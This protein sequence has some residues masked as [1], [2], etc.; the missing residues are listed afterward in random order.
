MKRKKLILGV[1]GFGC[2][3]RGLYEVLQHAP[4]TNAEIK[5]ICIK[6][7]GKQR[8]ADTTLFTDDKNIILHD[9]SINVVVELTDDADAAFEI[10]KKAMENGKAVV[11]ANKKMI[12]EHLYELY[13]LQQLYKVPFLYE[14]A[15]CAGIPIIRSLEEYYDNDLLFSLEGIMNGSTNYILSKI[16]DEQ[17]SFEHAL[18]EAQQAGFAET[19]PTLDIEAYDPKYKLCILLLHAFGI[20]VKQEHIFH[21]GIQ[22]L[23]DFDIAYARQR[24]CRIKLVAQCKK[25]GNHVY[26][27]VVPQFVELNSALT[28]VH[29]EFNGLILESAF[30]EYQFFSGRGAGSTAT[31]SAVLSDISALGYE[32]KYEYKKIGTAGSLEHN[33]NIDVKIYLR[34]SNEND[35]NEADFSSIEERYESG[36]TRYIAGSMK[37]EAI[38][39]AKW[40]KNENVSLISMQN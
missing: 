37:L 8:S 15:V 34:Y 40:L 21:F 39:A 16:F 28:N 5:K 17:K 29:H 2:V 18:G 20:F 14:G 6:N 23:N 31:G 24:N 35:I 27:Y 3:G 38:T 12:A 10:V 30:S 36:G 22:R 32:Y 19:D 1:F 33:Q 7:I 4:G 26:A 9:K 11:S 25:I 13:A